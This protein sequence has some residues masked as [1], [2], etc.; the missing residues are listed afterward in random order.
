MSP[1]N[2]KNF[3]YRGF[4]ILCKIKIALYTKMFKSKLSSKHLILIYTIANILCLAFCSIQ[5]KSAYI[6]NDANLSTEILSNQHDSTLRLNTS[7]GLSLDFADGLVV[8]I[9]ESAQHSKI[10]DM[11]NI[12]SQFGIDQS[13]DLENSTEPV[14]EY[15]ERIKNETFINSG[16]KYSE[17]NYSD[18]YLKHLKMLK[19]SGK[20]HKQSAE[21]QDLH[22]ED[23]LS[24][25]Q[26]NP[27]VTGSVMP[28]EPKKII[29]RIPPKLPPEHVSKTK[30]KDSESKDGKSKD[31]KSKDFGDESKSFSGT[32]DAKVI[33]SAKLRLRSSDLKDTIDLYDKVLEELRPKLESLKTGNPGIGPLEKLSQKSSPGDGFKDF[34]TSID[35]TAKQSEDL[36]KLESMETVKKLYLSHFKLDNVNSKINITNKDSKYG[37]VHGS[38]K[39]D[40]TEASH[41]KEENIET[42]SRNNNGTSGSKFLSILTHIMPLRLSFRQSST[43]GRGGDSSTEENM[44]ANKFISRWKGA[45]Q[46]SNKSSAGFSTDLN[47]SK[48]QSVG[49]EHPK[50]EI[51]FARYVELDSSDEED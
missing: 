29:R 20:L 37:K 50:Q 19:E 28:D 11:E 51:Y 16:I 38:T 18:I 10:F 47:L 39:S 21:Y 24:Y 27:P 26:K 48:A 15:E 7:I 31:G 2:L 13:S 34:S 42:P 9:L 3:I 33:K 25:H 12:T 8:G 30:S 41:P 23:Q 1:A 22:I 32:I 5:E 40:E 44:L 14:S 4:Y 49:T 17:K 43:V 36:T 45:I 6:G 35:E 46:G